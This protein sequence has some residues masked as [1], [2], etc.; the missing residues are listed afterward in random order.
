MWLFAFNVYIHNSKLNNKSKKEKDKSYIFLILE[1]LAKKG[2]N[3]VINFVYHAIIKQLE[4]NKHNRIILLSDS[5]GG[6]NKNY[7]FLQFFSSLSKKLKFGL[8]LNC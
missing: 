8:V 1:G 7:L 6:Q 5:C 4:A 3:T 2:S